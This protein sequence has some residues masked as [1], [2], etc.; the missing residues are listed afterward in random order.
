MV[1]IRF[2]KFFRTNTGKNLLSIILGVG[3][4]SLF[5]RACKNNQC[6]VYYAPPLEHIV[7]K[8]FYKD[9]NTNKCSTYRAEK[10]SCVSSKRIIPFE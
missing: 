5:R 8:S 1:F 6:R 3:L 9:K 4:A 2:E 7:D 10:V